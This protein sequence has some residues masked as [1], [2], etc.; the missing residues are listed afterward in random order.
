M[1]PH[2]VCDFL[3]K[4]CAAFNSFYAACPVLAAD[5]AADKARRLQIVGASLVIIENGLALLGISAP[6]KM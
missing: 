4:Y 2:Q 6:E 1:Q 3:L 5:D